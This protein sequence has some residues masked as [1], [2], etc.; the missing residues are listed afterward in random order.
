TG[1]QGAAGRAD[2]GHPRRGRPP[3]A[4]RGRHH[5]GGQCDRGRPED[6][7]AGR[8]TLVSILLSRDSRVLVQGLTGREGSFH[9][10][11]MKAYGTRVVAGVSPGKGGATHLGLPVFDTV[12]DAKAATGATVS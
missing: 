6:R 4:E 1:S 3:H 2:D 10:E 9:T 7:P 11:A 12:A 5:A 8:R